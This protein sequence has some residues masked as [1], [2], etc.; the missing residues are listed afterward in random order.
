MKR[1]S[2]YEKAIAKLTSGKVAVFE[3]THEK[4]YTLPHF[5]LASSPETNERVICTTRSRA[6]SPTSG[7]SP[8]QALVADARR[9]ADA[10]RT[11]SRL[12]SRDRLE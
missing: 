7:W 4:V 2:E 10:P 1:E 5:S 8:F 9:R 12:V 11:R 3:P 6:V